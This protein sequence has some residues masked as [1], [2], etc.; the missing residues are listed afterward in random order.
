MY[1]RD[2]VVEAGKKDERG[3][4]VLYIPLADVLSP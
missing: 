3:G 2:R 1:K 4:A